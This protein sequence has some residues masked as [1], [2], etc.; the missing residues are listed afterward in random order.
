[1]QNRQ[2]KVGASKTILLDTQNTRKLVFPAGGF[3]G[4]REDDPIS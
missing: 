1:M 3:G 2:R 4:Q